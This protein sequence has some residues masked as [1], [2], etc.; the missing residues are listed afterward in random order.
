MPFG[1]RR[2]RGTPNTAP[3]RK[4]I[5][6]VSVDFGYF[7]GTY[8]GVETTGELLECGHIVRPVE[9]FVGVTHA[10]RRR[11]RPCEKGEPVRN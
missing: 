4:I 9:D 8:E 3:L 1:K 7:T 11:C 6:T 5:E 2:R 10:V